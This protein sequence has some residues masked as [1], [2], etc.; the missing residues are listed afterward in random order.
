MLPNNSTFASKSVFAIAVAIS[1]TFSYHALS[2][3]KWIDYSGDND[4]LKLWGEETVSII[5]CSMS[6]TEKDAAYDAA[7]TWNDPVGTLDLFAM[8]ENTNPCPITIDMD[9]HSSTISGWPAGNSFLDG[10]MGIIYIHQYIPTGRIEGFD[11]GF[12]RDLVV[13]ADETSA[14]WT[15][16]GV[17][18]HEFGHAAGMAHESRYM[19][20]MND[21]YVKGKMGYRSHTGTVHSSVSSNSIWPDDMQYMIDY[22][23]SSNVGT[24][25]PF[26]SGWYWDATSSRGRR[27]YASTMSLQKCRGNTITVDFTVGNKG[28]QTIGEVS[29]G[30]YFSSDKTINNT[31]TLARAGSFWNFGR[32]HQRLSRSVTVPNSLSLNTKYYVGVIVDYNNTLSE[33][34]HYNNSSYLNYEVNI[35]NCN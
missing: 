27:I 20:V 26:A 9:D 28:K 25:D 10:G 4:H 23:E 17:I 13:T 34:N 12:N 14:D 19:S 35:I 11:V 8:T 33:D 16:L 22:Q 7:F 5:N 21:G 24:I 32:S 18:L 30:V 1:I 6:S 3:S 31:D 15:S 29:Y 2:Y